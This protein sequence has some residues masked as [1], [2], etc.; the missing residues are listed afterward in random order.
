MELNDFSKGTIVGISQTFFGHPLDT[1]KT[2]KQN[3]TKI[4]GENLRSLYRGIYYPLILSTTYNSL[5][6]GF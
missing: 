3:G 5:L 2:L 1:L 6:F 4:Q